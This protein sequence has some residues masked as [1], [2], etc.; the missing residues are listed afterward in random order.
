[1]GKTRTR[2]CIWLSP[3]DRATL[4][5]WIAGRNTPQKL[6]WRARIVSLSADQA[7]VMSIVRSVAKS[8]V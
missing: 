8:K 4:T 7:G 6:V 3:G 5:D 2:A 1:M